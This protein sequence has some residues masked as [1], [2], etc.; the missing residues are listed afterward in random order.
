VGQPRDP[1]AHRAAGRFAPVMTAPA[2]IIR[3]WLGYFHTLS[4]TRN[5]I[6]AAAA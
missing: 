4:R 1:A 6:R 5:E 3:H 2:W